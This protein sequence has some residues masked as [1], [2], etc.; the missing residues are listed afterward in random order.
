MRQLKNSQSVIANA[1]SAIIRL[2]STSGP[3]NVSRLISFRNV[4]SF[5]CVLRRWWIANVSVKSFKAFSPFGEDCNSLGTVPLI[6]VVGFVMA[7]G[8][9][10]TPG[11]INFGVRHAVR[12]TGFESS[13]SQFLYSS[14]RSLDWDFSAI[15]TAGNCVTAHE[16]AGLNP[17]SVS[18]ITLAKPINATSGFWAAFARTDNNQAS[19]S[20]TDSIY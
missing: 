5:N 8:F 16:I 17:S 4:N 6:I 3:T 10:V 15:T 12:P 20:L 18:A 19:G 1:V 11:F 9:N 14:N 2:F 7:S 13:A